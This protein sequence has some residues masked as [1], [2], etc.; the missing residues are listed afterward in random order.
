MGTLAVPILER[1]KERGGD[2]VLTMATTR[3]AGVA[4]NRPAPEGKPIFWLSDCVASP[5][6][7]YYYASLSRL[8]YNQNMGFQRAHYLVK[9][10]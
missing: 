6:H 10:Q 4:E 7:S 5:Q 9:A 1:D 3:D 2:I 8:A